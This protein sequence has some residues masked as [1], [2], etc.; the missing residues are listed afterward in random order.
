MTRESY[1]SIPIAAIHIFRSLKK[2]N[3]QQLDQGAFCAQI[4]NNAIR[5]EGGSPRI[6]KDRQKHEKQTRGIWHV[7]RKIGLQKQRQKSFPKKLQ[8]AN[9]W[10]CE[11][12]Q[13]HRRGRL[14]AVFSSSTRT[15]H[16][17]APGIFPGG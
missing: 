5:G 2:K 15:R 16:A 6:E 4:A 9:E 17:D 11:N 7:L 13:T 10:I 1:L 12:S 8:Y 14:S 3:P